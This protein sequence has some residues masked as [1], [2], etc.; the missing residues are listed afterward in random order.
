MLDKLPRP[1]CKADWGLTEPHSRGGNCF[2]PD[3]NFQPDL[4]RLCPQGTGLT[5]AKFQRADRKS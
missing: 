5:L 3:S 4:K 1:Q 2:S